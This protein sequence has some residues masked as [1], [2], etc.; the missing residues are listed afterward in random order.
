MIHE[1][2]KLIK[3]SNTIKEK[4]GGIQSKPGI[5]KDQLLNELKD[6]QQDFT[7]GKIDAFL[8]KYQVIVGLEL[9][10]TQPNK[11]P[12][13]G[14]NVFCFNVIISILSIFNIISF[15]IIVII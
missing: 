14:N 15:S 12:L 10:I 13:S 5:T 7:F 4:K 1:S 11:F 6:I 3:P 9:K 2:Q 8:Q